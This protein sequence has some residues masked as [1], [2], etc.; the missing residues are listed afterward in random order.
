MKRFLALILSCLLILSLIACGQKEKKGEDKTSKDNQENVFLPE[1]IS[2][3]MEDNA[4][5]KNTVVKVSEIKEGASFGIA[6]T[7]LQTSAEKFVLYDIVAT[8]D[9]A[10]VQPNG[11][12]KATFPIGKDYDVNRVSVVY[13][14]DDGKT[15][16]VPSEIDKEKR[17]VTAELSH[18][19]LYAVI[20]S[21]IK[22][23]SSEVTT[24]TPN[25]TDTTPNT[26]PNTNIA[27]THTY[28]DATCTAPKTCSKCKVTT[29]AALGHNYT[30]GTCTRCKAADP[31]YKYPVYLNDVG[32]NLGTEIT[33]EIVLK[34]KDTEINVCPAYTF[35][36]KEGNSWVLTDELMDDVNIDSEEFLVLTDGHGGPVLEGNEELECGY[37]YW[38]FSESD[39]DLSNG[40]TIY[41]VK[42]KLTKEGSYKIAVK[43]G[44]NAEQNNNKY[45]NSLSLKIY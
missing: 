35:S 9:K 39:A 40:K 5:P 36:K 2:I 45:T 25:T 19:S 8:L 18:F 44:Y 16:N 30:N 21:L 22:D 32:Y 31:N 20:E 41:R 1:N 33:L 29:G 26:S 42:C 34:T 24:D 13:I 37:W 14:S 3:D 7:A 23:T 4:F 11:T 10:T 6:S 15:E 27:C 38:M 43:D 12:I 17:T 28:T